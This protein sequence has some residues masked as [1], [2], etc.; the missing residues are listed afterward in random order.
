[1]PVGNVKKN[2]DSNVNNH[3]EKRETTQSTQKE[4]EQPR[5]YQTEQKR[6]QEQRESKPLMRDL[7]RSQEVRP[8]EKEGKAK[9]VVL[10]EKHL[11]NSHASNGSGRTVENSKT[12][13]APEGRV[14]A[15]ISVSQYGRETKEPKAT[16][17]ESPQ[18]QRTR[19]SAKGTGKPLL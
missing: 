6:T 18:T 8:T 19:I 3:T 9:A 14:K 13:A 15:T 2:T 11:E 10:S 16:K 4:A 7:Q 17:K 1:V 12:S 5:A